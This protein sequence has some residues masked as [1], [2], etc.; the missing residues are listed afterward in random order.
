MVSILKN[1]IKYYNL[2]TCINRL[3]C[4]SDKIENITTAGEFT[5]TT[6]YIL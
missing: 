2:N 6:N 4:N 1:P 3:A 5:W